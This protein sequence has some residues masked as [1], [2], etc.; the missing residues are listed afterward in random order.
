MDFKL[1][2][3]DAGELKM[4]QD[5]ALDT[6]NNVLL[7][8]NI[9]KGSYFHKPDFGSDLHNI[10]STTDNDVQLAKQRAASAIKWMVDAQKISNVKIDAQKIT[11]G[12][13][14]VITYEE[15]L[16]KYNVTHFLRVS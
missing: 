9:K 16:I 1:I 3:T 15:K 4:T 2:T 6:R 11:H 12:I 8:L 7:S 5:I 10:K 13:T 14:L